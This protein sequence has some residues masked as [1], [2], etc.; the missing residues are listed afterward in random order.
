MNALRLIVI[1]MIFTFLAGHARAS[2]NCA[3]LMGTCDYYTCV[4]M[5]LG[6]SQED[7][8]IKFGYRF[9]KKYVD[10]NE[11]YSANGQIFLSNVRNCLQRELEK[12][13]ELTCQ[14]VGAVAAT[15]HEAC[16]KKAGFCNLSVPDK[17][18]LVKSIFKKMLKDSKFR[19]SALKIAGSC[20]KKVRAQPSPDDMKADVGLENLY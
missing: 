19:A 4:S 8:P 16:Y 5:E 12:S 6:C 2:R 17:T 11:K 1:T 20:V 18:L 9:C 13:N 7:Y 14:N 15:Q 3:Y 10:D